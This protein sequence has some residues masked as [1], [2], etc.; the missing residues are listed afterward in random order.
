VIFKPR[1]VAIIGASRTPGKVGHTL[2]KN[3]LECGYAGRIYPINPYAEE[4]LGIRCY[5]S[6]LKVP[7]EVE[8]AVVAVPAPL[9]FGVAEECGEKGVHALIVISA[10]FRETGKEGAERERKLLEIAKR[11]GMRI[12]GPNCLGVID[13][14]TPLNLSFAPSMPRRGRIAFISQSGALATAALDWA[15]GE[16]IGFSHFIS[17]GNKADLN[18]IDFLQA[19]GGDENVRAIILYVES[20]EE[21]ERFMEVASEI[22]RNKPIIVLKGGVSKAGSRA[23]GSHTGALVGSYTAYKAAFRKV[24]VLSTEG[25]E[26]LFNYAVTLTEQPLPKGEGVV[27]VTNAG[28][29]GIVFTDLCERYR[30]ELAR[31]SVE[32]HRVLREVLPP[33]AATGNPIDVLGD[34]R[35]DRYQYA[36]ERV[37]EDNA[38]YAAAVI[39]TPQA[40]TESLA[41]AKAVVEMKDRFPDKPLVAVFMGGG[42][43]EE[44][45]RY[46]KKKGVPC[47]DFPEKAVRTL[48]ALYA[49]A[50]YLKRPVEKPIRFEDVDAGRVRCILESVRSEGRVVLLP[51]EAAEVVRAYG[52]DAPDMRVA[53]SEREAVDHAEELGY[54]VV[55]KVV[56]PDILH[57]TDIGGVVLNLESAE[58][59]RSAYRGIVARVSRHMPHARIHGVL[60]Y[61]MAPQGREMIIGMNRDIQFGPL[62]MFGLGGI[63]VNFLRDVS[64]A[65]TPLSKGEVE[66]MIRGTRA[67]TLLRGIRGEP[68]ADL[69]ALKEV[70]LR[71]GQLSV[72]FPEIVELD[73]N[74]LMVYEEGRGCIAVDVKLILGVG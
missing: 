54:P 26:E 61:S 20:I 71:V 59:V 15:M 63:Y 65:L 64:F 19:L 24:G 8:L 35:A 11:Y 14:Y 13:T 16:G 29:P 38:V 36:L 42:E 47:F 72:D 56:S 32:T 58:E 3:L 34:A 68:P 33:E 17:L 23:A 9:V 70:I 51:H 25:V 66:E 31:L 46:L 45:S 73:I 50:R 60:I 27:I 39:L 67:Y 7:S 69:D 1:S 41:T 37:L 44:A 2:L 49:Y 12:Q 18:E 57:K 48:S 10:G 62:I 52:V 74:P 40:M 6:V 55:L 43:V 4:I 53:T 21:G 22:T 5:P 30:V 28:G